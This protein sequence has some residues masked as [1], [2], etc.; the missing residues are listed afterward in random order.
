MKFEEN[1]KQPGSRGSAGSGQLARAMV[2]I[3]QRPGL[4]Q[5]DEIKVADRL[6][7]VRRGYSTRRVDLP[8][9]LTLLRHAV[10]PHPGDLV[11]ARV[12][13]IGHHTRLELPDG[14]R[15]SLYKGD[16]I[17]VSYANRYAPDQFEAEVPDDLDDCHLVASGGIASKLLSKS[18]RSRNPTRI[19]PIGLL[20]DLQGTPLNLRQWQIDSRSIPKPLPPVLVVSGTSMNA[21]KTTAASRLIRGLVRGGKRV[22]A[23]KVTGTGAGGDYWKMKDAGACDV[24]DFIDA[25]H[26]STYQLA[27]QE[28]EQVFLRLLSHLGSRGL[29]AIVVEVA[30]GILQGETA[31]LLG[32]PGFAYYCDRMIFAAGDAMGAVAGVHWLQQRGLDVC[33]VSG[34]LTA[35]PLAIRETSSAIGLP[36]LSKQE[37]SDPVVALALL[38]GD[39]I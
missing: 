18:A 11:L 30:D 15:S 36:V 21:G 31:G 38:T 35:S 4:H 33:A 6:A 13:S 26:A 34:A 8:G 3:D 32:S 22:G 17:I 19:R 10:S 24:V 7:G 27:P 9:R 25:G 1:E 37:L 16:E 28:V 2:H 20:A 23:A 14:R 39:G 29:D 5:V 12:S